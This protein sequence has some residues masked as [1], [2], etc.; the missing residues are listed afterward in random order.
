MTD[1]EALV[2]IAV[3]CGIAAGGCGL[4]CRAALRDIELLQRRF[5]TPQA[6]P[7]P[8]TG[9]ERTPPASGRAAVNP[10]SALPR[11]PLAPT[12]VADP[13]PGASVGPDTPAGAVAPLL[14]PAASAGLQTPVG[15]FEAFEP[16]GPR[17]RVTIHAW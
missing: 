14:P 7:V 3:F 12:D 5:S 6:E 16:T 10:P 17:K 9:V 13:R 4:L 11:S 15:S 1:W 2:F 8:G